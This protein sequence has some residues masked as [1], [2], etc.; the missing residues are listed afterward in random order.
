MSERP[1]GVASGE[2]IS[3][4]SEKDHLETEPAALL[5]REL[6]RWKFEN[7]EVVAP[8][9]VGLLADSGR[10]DD[11]TA[12]ALARRA[13]Q[14]Y[15]LLDIW[16]AR[17]LAGRDSQEMRRILVIL[18]E[19]AQSN[20]ILA[21]LTPVFRTKDNVVRS[22]AALLLPGSARTRISRNSFEKLAIAGCWR[23]RSRVSGVRAR[24][25][26]KR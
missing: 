24:Q 12:V 5:R 17:A 8:Q 3:A 9:L 15:P 22:K 26:H 16:L 20:R 11:E 19:I 13:W 1:A 6:T 2:A 25:G 18:S 21:S 23:T 10:F 14:A 4:G 7:H